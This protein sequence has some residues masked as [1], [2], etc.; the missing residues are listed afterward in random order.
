MALTISMQNVSIEPNYEMNLFF[1]NLPQEL[2]KY[3]YMI[4]LNT[5]ISE[6][7]YSIIAQ[8]Q[9]LNYIIYDLYENWCN[10]TIMIYNKVPNFP[11]IQNI[12][13]EY[14]LFD[15]YVPN[16]QNIIIFMCKKLNTKFC[17]TNYWLG[18]IRDCVHTLE[19]YTEYFMEITSNNTFIKKQMAN[20]T[21]QMLIMVENI[22]ML[23]DKF[24]FYNINSTLFT[25]FQMYSILENI[26]NNYLWV[27]SSE[28]N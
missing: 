17:D 25:N 2:R 28:N 3:I 26:E 22:R 19:V 9:A 20:L 1:D 21:K 15:I 10:W 14:K 4:N 7:Y 6:K 5:L 13:G 18:F 24:R 8:K 12:F 23:L 11:R 27:Q 16:V